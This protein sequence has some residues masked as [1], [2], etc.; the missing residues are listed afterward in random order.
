MKLWLRQHQ[1]A[2]LQALTGAWHHLGSF[3]FNAVVLAIA[4]ALP[5]AGFTLLENLRPVSGQLAVEPEISLFLEQDTPRAKAQELEPAIRA[6]LKEY[7]SAAS[8]EFVP[9]EQALAI[10]QKRSSLS[11]ALATLGSNPLPDGYVLRLQGVSETEQAG[12]IGQ[13]AARLAALPGVETLQ[14]DSD[15][16]KRLAA[17]IN[18]LRVGLVLLACTLGMVVIAV[19]FNTIRL[20]VM[21]QQEEIEVSRLVGATDA[22]IQRP[23]YYNGALLGLCGG[24]LALA[25][26]NLGLQPLNTAIADFARLYASE[27]RLFAL[28]PALALTLLAIAAAL[29]WCGALLSVKRQLARLARQGS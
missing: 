21:T 2:L 7:K 14:V 27:F 6:I 4:L 19:V 12:R 5:F 10:L 26:V 28:P 16:I 24:I 29:G 23:F 18:N 8:V 17:L 1:Q 15:W 9:R 20:Q 3:S 11:D 25:V 13:I 22:Y